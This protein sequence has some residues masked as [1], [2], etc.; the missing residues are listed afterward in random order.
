MNLPDGSRVRIFTD[1]EQLIAEFKGGLH[2]R[3][4]ELIREGLLQVTLERVRE[5]AN[6]AREFFRMPSK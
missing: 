5:E 1:S 3:A 4:K 6:L 2:S